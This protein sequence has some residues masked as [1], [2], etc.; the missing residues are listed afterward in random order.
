V[1]DNLLQ[2][3]NAPLDHFG[4]YGLVEASQDVSEL[5][6]SVRVHAVM[7]GIKVHT[8][9]LAAPQRSADTPIKN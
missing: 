6:G 5:G 1:R 4:L 9:Q 8:A 3:G 7:A 2:V